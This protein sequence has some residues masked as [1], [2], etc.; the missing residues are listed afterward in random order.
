M[1][2]GWLRSFIAGGAPIS[3]RFSCIRPGQSADHDLV[4]LRRIDHRV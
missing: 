3:R 1:T 4:Q 2:G